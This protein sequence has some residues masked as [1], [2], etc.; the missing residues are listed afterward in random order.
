VGILADWRVVAGKAVGEESEHSEGCSGVPPEHNPQRRENR[1][2][3]RRHHDG[4]SCRC[5]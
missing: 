3:L 5:R 1:S 4:S 2:R